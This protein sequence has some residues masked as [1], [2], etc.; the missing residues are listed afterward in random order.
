[1]KR[2]A[3]YPCQKKTFYFKDLKS[4]LCYFANTGERFMNFNKTFSEKP[5]E[6]QIHI[7]FA[8]FNKFQRKN[9]A[10]LN[11]FSQKNMA[12]TFFLILIYKIRNYCLCAKILRQLEKYIKM[13]KCY[14]HSFILNI[15]LFLVDINRLQ[16]K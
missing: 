3:T 5:F 11:M 9:S 2:L 14:L 1:M 6:T 15:F 8:L 10:M 13:C 4:L 12:S 7:F 16:D